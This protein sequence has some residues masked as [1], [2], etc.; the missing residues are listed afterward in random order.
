ML[1]KSWIAYLTSGIAVRLSSSACV[2]RKNSLNYSSTQVTISWFLYSMRHSQ[3]KRDRSVSLSLIPRF[4]RA[5]SMAFRAYSKIRCNS[6]LLSSS[7]ASKKLKRTRLAW[8][9]TLWLQLAKLMLQNC[10]SARPF[11]MSCI[12]LRPSFVT[13][14]LA[15][16]FRLI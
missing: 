2:S 7:K 8:Y 11:S 6:L 3:S 4:D 14:I 9:M 10:I 5:S 12:A 1:F 16:S 15:R 13:K